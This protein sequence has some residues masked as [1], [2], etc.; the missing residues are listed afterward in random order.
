MSTKLFLP[1]LVIV[2]ILA[3]CG[4]DSSSSNTGKKE[5]EVSETDQSLLVRDNSQLNNIPNLPNVSVNPTDSL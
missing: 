4:G 3:G 5:I 1:I 2:G